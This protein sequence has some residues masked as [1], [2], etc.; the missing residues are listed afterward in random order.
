MAPL[1]LNKTAALPDFRGCCSVAD[2]QQCLAEA[3]YKEWVTQAPPLY[4]QPLGAL[5][6]NWGAA[7]FTAPRVWVDGPIYT[8]GFGDAPT[9]YTAPL[10]AIYA[11]SVLDRVEAPLR[12]LRH[13]IDLLRPGGLLVCTFAVWDADGYD[14]ALGHELRARIYN[15]GS[16]KKLL[17]E[18]R[19]IDLQPFGG[20]DLRY[21]GDT[22]GDHTLA[23]LVAVTPGG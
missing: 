14:C 11:L 6:Y 1:A 20:V 3:A 13:T 9:S 7:S 2:W 18:V 10:D 15:R 4:Q 12:F 19:L 16:W 8:K 5:V 22:L 23:T 21:H 17:E